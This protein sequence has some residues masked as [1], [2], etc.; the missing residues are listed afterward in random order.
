MHSSD[1]HGILTSL[2]IHAL[3]LVAFLFVE[4]KPDVTE[5]LGY[6]QVDFG[7]FAEGRPVQNA[8]ETRPQPEPEDIEPEVEEEPQPTE[9]EES[10]PVDLPDADPVVDEPPIESPDTEVEAID[11][12]QP[13]DETQ[14]EEEEREE[15]PAI[16]PL[17]SGNTEGRTGAEE[18]DEGE[19]TDEQEAAP[20]QIE[21]LNRTPVKTPLPTYASP[22]NADIA[23]KI[24]VSPD[25]RISRQL[26]LRKGD[27]RLEEAVAIALRQWRFN[28]L[29]SNVPQELQEGNVVFRFRLE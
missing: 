24:W 16:R 12:V 29:P 26:V 23:V 25:G 3:L 28:P 15:T 1:W 2:V 6:I 14:V 7:D 13:E 10:K 20:F 18:G 9:P 8:P 17:G 5:Q 19:G 4:V 11:T 22:V 21:G 27:P